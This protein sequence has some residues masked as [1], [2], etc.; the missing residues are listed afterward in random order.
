VPVL[1]V[2][3]AHPT[4]GPPFAPFHP[5]LQMQEAVVVLASGEKLFAGQSTQPLEPK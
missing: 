3:A 1:Y 5:A 2:P 4:H